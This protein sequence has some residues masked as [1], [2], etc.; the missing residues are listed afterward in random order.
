VYGLE[1]VR[2]NEVM[3]YVTGCTK[4]GFKGRVMVLWEMR[5]DDGRKKRPAGILC[6]FNTDSIYASVLV[7]ER[8]VHDMSRKG[9]DVVG[10]GIGASI[11]PI[12]AS[13]AEDI[14]IANR[15]PGE[16]IYFASS[17][18]SLPL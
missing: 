10:V 17:Q 6:P 18:P 11:R 1:D 2:L 8:G 4:N 16:K 3:A 14:Q 5:V 15:T 9:N 12:R 7:E 13:D